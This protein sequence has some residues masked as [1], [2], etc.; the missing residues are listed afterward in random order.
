MNTCLL[1]PILT[2]II[3]ALLGYLLGRMTASNKEELNLWKGKYASLEKELH[4]TRM[5]LNTA[6]NTPRVLGVEFDAAMAESVMGRIIALDDL[7]VVEGIGPQ[8]EKLFH[9]HGITTWGHLANSSVAQCQEILDSD[10]ERF[11]IHDP[12]TWPEQARLAYE[13]KWQE[14]LA[15]QDKLKGGK[16]E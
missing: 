3:A 2:G 15:L 9:S 7:K 5:D 1:I 8:I 12:G 10:G 11:K 6:L 4:K 16:F 13:G 14:L